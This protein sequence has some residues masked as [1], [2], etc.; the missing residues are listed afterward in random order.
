[1][2]PGLLE[3]DRNMSERDRRAQMRATFRRERELSA[4][5]KLTDKI[6]KDAEISETIKNNIKKWNEKNYWKKI[7]KFQW[8]N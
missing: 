4:T 6:R 5:R 2:Q 1:V 8:T 3:N 7:Q